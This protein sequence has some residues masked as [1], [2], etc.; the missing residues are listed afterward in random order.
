MHLERRDDRELSPA[1]TS[2]HGLDVLLSPMV[3]LCF[4]FP[5]STQGSRAGIKSNA[6]GRSAAMLRAAGHTNLVCIAE[7]SWLGAW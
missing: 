5:L 1:G 3:D 6:P 4:P 2:W 7:P